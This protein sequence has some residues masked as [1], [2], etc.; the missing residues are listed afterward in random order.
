MKKS[1]TLFSAVLFIFTVSLLSVSN[2]YA[3]SKSSEQE[4]LLLGEWFPLESSN[5]GLGM[6]YTFNA[7]GKLTTTTGAFIALKYRFEGDTLTSIFPGEPEFKQKVVID[8]SKMIII[9]QTANTEFTRIAG[10]NHSGIVGTWS[11]DHYTG[12]KQIITFTPSHDEYLSVPMH[13][14][15]GT[16]KFKSDILELNVAT[17]S[18]Y[19]WSIKGDILEL[20]AIDSEKSY[21]YVRVNF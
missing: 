14:E 16:Y 9:D 2:S 8:S 4:S 10:E 3:Q 19:N 21:R 15:Q 5:S 7:D 6:G 18:S 1:T 11:G 20:K 17:T 13:S 12:A